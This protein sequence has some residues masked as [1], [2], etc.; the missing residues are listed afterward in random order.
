M[1]VSNQSEFI[2]RHVSGI[3]GNKTSKCSQ[4]IAFALCFYL[5]RNCELGNVSDPTS[6]SQ[7]IICSEKCTGVTELYKECISVE[8]LQ[9]AV[10]TQNE[11]LRTLFSLAARFVCSEPDT[12]IIP[13]VPVSNKSC[14]NF[15]YI[16]H[17]LPSDSEGELLLYIL[18]TFALYYGYII[19]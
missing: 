12:Y 13:H 5:F 9:L 2:L 14:D 3:T 8:N 11:A 7:L 18:H 6:G 15:S 1:A 19:I 4:F 10:N 16:D 17:L